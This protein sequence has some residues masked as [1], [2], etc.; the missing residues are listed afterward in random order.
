VIEIN[1]ACDFVSEKTRTDRPDE[2]RALRRKYAEDSD[3]LR[4]A[5]EKNFTRATLADVV[6]HIDHAVRIAGIDH[7]GIGSDFDGIDCAPAGLE[8]NSKF[9]AL[10]RALLEKGYTAEQI[11]KIYGAISCAWYAR[12]GV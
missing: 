11:H 12:S 4:A 3:A 8:D 9:P 1:F 6:A 7:V 10:T 2:K 5:V